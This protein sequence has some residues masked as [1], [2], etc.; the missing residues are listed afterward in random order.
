MKCDADLFLGPQKPTENIFE[1]HFPRSERL[2]R[3]FK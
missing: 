2:T 1:G 3:K